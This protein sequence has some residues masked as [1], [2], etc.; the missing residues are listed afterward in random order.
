V[1][2]RQLL[3]TGDAFSFTPTAGD[4]DGDT[5]TYSI[6]G[7]PNWMT[8]NSSTGEVSGTAEIGIYNN[9]TITVSDG[10]TGGV[11]TLV[12]DLTVNY[13]WV[14][15]KTGQTDCWDSAGTLLDAA[16]C[17]ISGQDGAYQMGTDPDFTRD[18]ATD[19][20]TDNLNGLMWQDDAVGSTMTWADAGTTCDSLSLGGHDDW[21]LPS[22]D[23]LESIVDFGRV[24]P[25]INSVFVNTASYVY[26]S[27]TTYVYYTGFAWAVGFDDGDTGAHYKG[28]YY[29]ARCVRS[30]Q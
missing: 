24:N 3:K 10:R 11:S 6:S 4:L 7:N 18:D 8:I 16:A 12:F 29:Y 27:S 28:N 22:I 23:E 14:L 17:L 1:A 2:H 5:L 9:I 26:W 21:R 20:V 30:G 19:I 15:T 25:A 13:P